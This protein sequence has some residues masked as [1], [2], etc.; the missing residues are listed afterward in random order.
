M[1]KLALVRFSLLSLSTYNKKK[2]L[3]ILNI[4]IFISIFALSA[5][6]LSIFFENKIDMIEKKILS[7]QINKI[8]YNDTLSQTAKHIKNTDSILD[9]NIKETGLKLLIK[10]SFNDAEFMTSREIYYSKFFILENK[11]ELNNLFIDNSL[12]NAILVANSEE[13]LK[14]IKT[15][16]KKYKTLKKTENEII[17]MRNSHDYENEPSRDSDN[18]FIYKDNEL[19]DW[20]RYYKFFVNQQIELIVIQKSFLYDF[21]IN[22][23]SK[24]NNEYDQRKN[25][26]LEIIEKNSKIESRAI[27]IA[28]AIQLFI[29]LISQFFEF[30]LDNFIRRKKNAKRK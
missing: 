29:F 6:F 3:N 15:F 4:G 22:Y 12:K 21:N 5:S 20:Y 25:K 14:L 17:F 8:I 18:N 23:F 28:F 13:D 1:A 19:Q 30:T 24:K 10:E 16:R 27:F 26:N 2:L 7:E 9:N 11:I